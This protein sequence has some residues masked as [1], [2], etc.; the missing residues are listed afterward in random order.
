MIF[1]LIGVVGYKIIDNYDY[2]FCLVRKIIFI[3]FL[4]IYLLICVYILNLV[5]SLFEKKFKIKR[6]ILIVF[7]YFIL[8]VMVFVGLFFIIL[9]IID[10][11]LNI[12]KDVFVYVKVV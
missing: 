2:F 11:I 12:I 3:M 5:V 6:F 8:V 4:F 9:S 10:S 1:V 7:M